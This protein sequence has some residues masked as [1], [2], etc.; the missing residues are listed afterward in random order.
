[1]RSVGARLF[2]RESTFPISAMRFTR[3]SRIGARD[4]V[5]GSGRGERLS[6]REPAAGDRELSIA[7]GHYGTTS[8]IDL[9]LNRPLTSD[10][11]EPRS[12][13]AAST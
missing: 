13:L 6:E 12:S 11:G 3:A 7:L 8:T 10:E 9:S 5:R 2:S 4:P 1:M